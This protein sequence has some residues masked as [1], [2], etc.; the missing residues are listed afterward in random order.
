MP[1]PS[2]KSSFP[3]YL[4]SRVDFLSVLSAAASLRALINWTML[5]LQRF[6]NLS[7]QLNLWLPPKTVF[8]RCHCSIA[9]GVLFYV[10]KCLRTSETQAYLV[11]DGVRR[12][13]QGLRS[14]IDRFA[15][16]FLDKNFD[17]LT[18][19]WINAGY[20]KVYY[21]ALPVVVLTSCVSSEPAELGPTP[22]SNKEFARDAPIS[23]LSAG[24][25]PKPEPLEPYLERGTGEFVAKENSN[26]EKKFGNEAGN[27]F[28]I[29]MVDAEIVEVIDQILGKQLNLDYLID[30]RVEGRITIRTSSGLPAD[31]ILSIL[32]SVLNLNGA[33][34]VEDD[35][36]YR[37]VPIDQILGAGI[38]PAVHPISN[39]NR[40]GFGV[41]IVPIRFIEVDNLVEILQPLLSADSTIKINGR[42]N[43]I[44]LVGPREE[45]STLIETIRIF[46]VDWMKGMSFGL[47]SLE[48]AN[49]LEL[50]NELGQVFR[51]LDDSATSKSV[52]FI[53]IKRLN[54]I[55]VIASQPHYLDRTRTWIEKLDRPADGNEERLFVYSVQN[56]RA[57]EIANILSRIFEIENAVVRK[58]QTGGK[59]S[60]IAP[61][62]DPIEFTTS[63][64]VPDGGLA[65][66]D[67][68]ALESETYYQQL[69]DY[70]PYENGKREA[71]IVA[72]EVNNSLLIKTTPLSF[73][74]I[75]A[76]IKEIDVQPVQVLLEATIAEVTLRDELDYGIQWFFR[77]GSSNVTLSESPSGSVDQ[78]FAGFSGLF[79]SNDIRAVFNALDSVS[80]VRIVSS[81]QI[82]VL[83]N[84]TAH[85]EVG[86]EVP[87]V[88]QQSQGTN[89][90]NDR[91]LNTIEQRQTGVILNVTPRVNASGLV[92]LDI[93]QEVSDVVRTTTSGIDSPTISQRRIGTSI[94]VG[95]HQTV[96]LGGLI[97][98]RTDQAKQGVPFLSHIPILGSLFGATSER[99]ARTE[100]LVLITPKVIRSHSEAQGVTEELRKRFQ[101]LSPLEQKLNKNRPY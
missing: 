99:F 11:F 40:V 17:I 67:R 54:A 66:F 6:F 101:S 35:G 100:L 72:D 37:I 34:L 39:I 18:D 82:L 89:S 80:D 57:S 28:R 50:V 16:E 32:D 55:V 3:N 60:L 77:F 14:C 21:L 90:D 88:T 46:D 5:L 79:P 33:A 13:C 87:I 2:Q 45:L 69:A 8:T 85:L 68:F 64:G 9:I 74:K 36:L 65:E 38:K 49:S 1:E 62:M 51:G 61:G 31:D 42:R 15:R 43:T 4:I 73:E 29:N 10:L 56:G 75:E 26:S 95:N 22:L 94:A 44:L 59:E 84:Q 12:S 86:D 83:D 97:R 41:E 96:A 58:D 78:L 48:Y 71:I 91:L 70:S 25:Q 92:V 93:Q 53:P 7:C 63:Q 98:D 23:I 19:R 47:F 27:E 20:G 24:S 30:P 81:P 52:R 76:A